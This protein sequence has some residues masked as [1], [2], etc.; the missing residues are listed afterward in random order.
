M[1]IHIRGSLWVE[2]S[3]QTQKLLKHLEKDEEVE[4]V[5]VQ[6]LGEDGG[7]RVEVLTKRGAKKPPLE[8]NGE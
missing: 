6:R 8:H 3:P 5:L 2:L 1:A 7:L 4:E